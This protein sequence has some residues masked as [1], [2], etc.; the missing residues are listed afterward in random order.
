M[1]IAIVTGTR[2][3]YGLLKTTIAALQETR[4]VEL[5][6]VATGMHLLREFGYTVR[7]IKSDGFEV[8]ARIPMQRG[9]DSATD[10]AEGLGRGVAG[11]ARFFARSGTNVAI[12]LGDRIEA[13]AG[14]LAAR[15]TGVKLAH[16]HGGDVA[17]GDFDGPMR[18]A[19]TQLADLHLTASTRATRRV[20]SMGAD[21]RRVVQ[22]GAPGLDRLRELLRESHEASAR[23]ALVVQHAYGRSQG[24]EER[25]MRVLLD[26]V[27]R[28]GLRRVIVCPNSDRGHAGV[29]RAIASHARRCR[30]DDVEVHTSLPRD[31]FLRR[32]MG[33]AVLIGNSST[34]FIEAPF[35]GTV[36]INVGARQ[37]GREAGGPSVLHARETGPSIRDALQRGLR[38]RPKPGRS[39]VYGGGDAGG[40][41]ARAVVS[42]ARKCT[43]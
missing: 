39:S 36:S 25:V 13:M 15:A 20:I 17:P 19:I 38:R 12:V 40:R 24:E 41:I 14:A 5:Q 30:G 18:D 37:E 1:R 9:D 6:V 10:Q 34:A 22:V 43:P 21:K 23:F 33:A 35:A 28:T 3:E 27:A 32:L 26:E 8:T 16:I 31:E 2:A 7:Q 11:M 42:F 29:S 4:G